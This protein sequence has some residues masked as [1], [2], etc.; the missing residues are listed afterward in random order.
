MSLIFT[1]STLLLQ[2]KNPNNM[3]LPKIFKVSGTKTV[4][5]FEGGRFRKNIPTKPIGKL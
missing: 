1:A 5:N 2:I 4:D 3:T